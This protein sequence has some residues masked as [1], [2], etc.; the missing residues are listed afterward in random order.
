M[1]LG[2]VLK[3]LSQQQKL[4]FKNSILTQH[5]TFNGNRVQVSYIII[6]IAVVQFYVC[7]KLCYFCSA[8]VNQQL[9]LHDLQ[10][11]SLKIFLI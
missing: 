5:G 3:V 1:Q 7:T 10:K 2:E 4:Y 9:F 11:Y 6:E 8:F